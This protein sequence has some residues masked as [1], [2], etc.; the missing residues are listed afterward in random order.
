[1]L[2]EIVVTSVAAVTLGSLWLADRMTPEVASRIEGL[3][4]ERDAYEKEAFHNRL[5]GL[6]S[7]ARERDEASK[8]C[9]AEI[10]R[11]RKTGRR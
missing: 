2:A 7:L 9:T 11:L 8:K 3:K 1:M 6:D 4:M 5:N 10:D